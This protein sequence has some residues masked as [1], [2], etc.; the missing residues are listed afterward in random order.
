MH[1]GLSMR[2]EVEGDAFKVDGYGGRRL[3]HRRGIWGGLTLTEFNVSTLPKI[4]FPQRNFKSHF[5][6]RTVL[7]MVNQLFYLFIPNKF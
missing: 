1:P 5:L 4:A 7:L 2:F 3:P 6:K